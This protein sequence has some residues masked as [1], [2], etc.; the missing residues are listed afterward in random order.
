MRM[1]TM[2]ACR[3]PSN[4][5]VLHQTRKRV[6]GERVLENHSFTFDELFDKTDDT[7]KVYERAAQ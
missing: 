3:S 5:A 4:T 6:D 2:D 7:A 1:F